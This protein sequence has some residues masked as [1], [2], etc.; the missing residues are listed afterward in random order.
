[1]ELLSDLDLGRIQI[2]IFWAICLLV[3][4][5]VIGAVWGSWLSRLKDE[6]G[7]TPTLAEAL[8]RL[9]RRAEGGG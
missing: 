7:R 5:L 4:Y 6:T 1:M 2:F 8:R 9:V 3:A